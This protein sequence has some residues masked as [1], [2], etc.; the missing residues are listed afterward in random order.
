MQRLWKVTIPNMK[1]AIMVAVLFRA[2]DAWRIFE[3]IFIMTAG[4]QKTESLSFLT[5]RQSITR[6]ALGIGSAVSVLLFVT[7]VIIAAIFLKG[8]KVDLGTVKGERR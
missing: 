7:M 5:Y 1:A 8:F 2:L 6:V 4:A 3:S